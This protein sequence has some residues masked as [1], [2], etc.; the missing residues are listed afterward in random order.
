M[1]SSRKMVLSLLVLFMVSVLFPVIASAEMS[2]SIS[3]LELASKT[4][5]GFFPVNKIYQGSPAERAGIREGDLLV[6]VD[7]ADI[8]TMQNGEV[9][10]LLSS[11]IGVGESSVLTLLTS[12]GKDLKWLKPLNLSLEQQNVLDF[13]QKLKMYSQVADAQWKG[14]VKLFQDCVMGREEMVTAEGEFASLGQDIFHTRHDIMG[15][16]LPSGISDDLEA[17]CSALKHQFI[18][19][20]TK[21]FSAKN[22]ML[23]YAQARWGNASFIEKRWEKAQNAKTEAEKEREKTAFY[24]NRLLRYLEYPHEDMVELMNE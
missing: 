8:S 10:R 15:V 16:S 18:V 4:D 23:D 14:L 24:I 2:L 12:H 6:E 5:N 21:R 7:H 13:Y 17:L 1:R 3:G 20:Q 11:R 19:T 22:K 9:E